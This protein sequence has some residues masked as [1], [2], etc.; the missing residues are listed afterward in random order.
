VLQADTFGDICPP[1]AERFLRL[2]T[3]WQP[4]SGGSRTVMEIGDAWRP[5]P[6]TSKAKTEFYDQFF[7]LQPW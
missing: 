6:L 5:V 4:A 7:A 3:S 2:V 1:M